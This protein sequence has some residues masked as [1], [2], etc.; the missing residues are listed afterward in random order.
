M[1][2]RNLLIGLLILIL[3]ILAAALVFIGIANFG[4]EARELTEED[5]LTNWM[6]TLDNEASLN[7]IY[8]PGT[9]DSGALHSFLGVSGQ[10][11]SYTIK[12]QL[13][14][15]IRFF[16][17][18][19]QLREDKLCVVHSFVDQKLTFEEVLNDFKAF[20]EANPS[21]F[22]IVS[23]KEDANAE[24]S[25]V[26]FEKAAEQML[27][28]NLGSLL[29]SSTVLPSTIGEARGMIHIVARYSNA[30]VGVPAHS[31]WADSTSFEL[32]E[33]YVQDYYAIDTVE[34]KIT[35]IV[36][37]FDVA[38]ENKHELVLNFTSCYLVNALP[39]A[40][41]PTA[42]KLINPQLSDLIKEGKAAPCVFVSDFVT[43][44]FIREIV[45]LNF[46]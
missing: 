28:S 3:V 26:P 25:T 5:L 18:R 43:P 35:D 24:H 42:A 7:E 12:Q 30:S 37:A 9:H 4:V 39:P 10:C 22:L 2:F 11:Q 44:E 1:F 16:D 29:N 13:D 45:A 31:G 20:L 15:G 8:I 6:S 17:I 33:L 46:K 38:K 36:K 19:L 34:S 32:G 40:H 21:E 23:I 41:A 27:A 14:M